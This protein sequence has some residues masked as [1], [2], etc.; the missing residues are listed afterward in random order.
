MPDRFDKARQIFAKHNGILRTAEAVE[1]GIAPATLYAMRDEG[2]LIELVRGV[3]RLAEYPSLTNPDFV[4]VARRHPQAVICLISALNYYELTTQIPH[5]VYVAFLKGVKRPDAP[6]PP[7]EVVWL[8]PGAYR[9]G[10]EIVNI[11]GV[12]VKIYS[13][14][15]TICD[16][17]KFRNKIG[18]D[19]ALEGLR[20]YFDQPQQQWNIPKLLEYAR[21]DRVEKLISPYIKALL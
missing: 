11:D 5:A 9:A 2:Q 18:E 20:N 12:T 8:S 4:I 1:A 19:V 3:F 21:L 17:F 13:K 16:C 7:I 6:Y 10:I 15:K 14:E